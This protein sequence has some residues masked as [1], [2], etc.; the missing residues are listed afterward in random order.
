M[1]ARS[2]KWFHSRSVWSAIL[3]AVSGVAIS[4]AL[5]LS[6]EIS[7]AEFLPGAVALAWGAVDVALR[8]DTSKAIK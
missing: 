6:S 4:L 2:K 8:F 1:A 7:F 3:K 5:V